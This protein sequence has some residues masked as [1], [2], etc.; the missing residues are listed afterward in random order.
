MA[1]TQTQ[2]IEA[3]ILAHG[4]ALIKATHKTKTFSLPQLD[5]GS[6]LYLGNAG[7]LRV[8]KTKDVSIPWNRLKAEYLKE[9]L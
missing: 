5:A 8:G 1:R 7:S 6:Y 2:R 4:G 9:Q 3:A